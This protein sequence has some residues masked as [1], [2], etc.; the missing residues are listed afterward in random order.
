LDDFPLYCKHALDKGAKLYV[1]RVVPCTVD[2]SVVTFSDVKATGTITET[3]KSAVFEAV[4]VGAGYN[5]SVVIVAKSKSGVS[6]KI[7]ISVVLKGSD[8]TTTVSNVTSTPDADGIASINLQ[9]EE[10]G[11]KLKTV[12]LEI[13]VGSV[14]LTGG[15]TDLSDLADANFIGDS[16]SKTGIYAFDDITDCMR[17]FNFNRPSAAVDS[18][19]VSYCETRGDMR[20]RLRTPIGLS[21]EGIDSY[22][23]GVS[24]VNSLYAEYAYTDVVITDPFNSAAKKTVSGIGFIAGNRAKVDADYGVWFS[25]AGERGKI[26]VL[27]V[28]KNYT[29]PGN[30]GQFDS[31]YEAGLNAIVIDEANGPCYWGNRNSYPDK[32]KLTSKTNIAD[33]C[34][35]IV[36]EI[37]KIAKTK[38]FDP[39][40]LLMIR[41]LYLKVK[42]F[43][44]NTL[45]SGRA[46]EGNSS[47]NAG[48]GTLWYWVGDQNAKTINEMTFNNPT[49]V[50]AGSYKAQFI[51]KP[52]AATEYIAITVSPADSAT[53]AT[54]EVINS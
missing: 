35:Y 41:Q 19:I 15:T 54:I 47:S 11:V 3:T 22:I 30:K 53:I 38:A 39:T 20:A 25:D 51:F 28:P 24:S 49:D 13:P 21:D 8:Q 16:A 9:L 34:V 43:I 14:S 5:G 42:P 37:I 40:D 45:I 29:S 18:A 12:T 4:A 2:D 32:T 46:I 23:N 50:D 44:K 7:D 52:K 33:L 36:R 27:D 26:N 31:L 10:A 6:G 48:E 1:V 17:I